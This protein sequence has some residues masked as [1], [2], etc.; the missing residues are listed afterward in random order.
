MNPQLRMILLV[1]MFFL[2]VLPLLLI[3]VALMIDPSIQTKTQCELI[4][5][6]SRPSAPYLTRLCNYGHMDDVQG[7]IISIGIPINESSLAAM[8]ITI[9][10]TELHKISCLVRCNQLYNTSSG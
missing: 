1:T 7:P 3:P 4:D 8:G 9:T 10:P 6:N 2:T 5:T